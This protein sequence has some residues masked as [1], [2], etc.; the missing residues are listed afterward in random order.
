MFLHFNFNY[1]NR[2]YLNNVLTFYMFVNK[3]KAISKLFISIVRYKYKS[4]IKLNTQYLYNA[5]S[6]I[7]LI[8]NTCAC[9]RQH[10]IQV[11]FFI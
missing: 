4:F 10:I 11:R 7:I 5:V 2:I 6:G 3:A 8:N 9:S 1:V